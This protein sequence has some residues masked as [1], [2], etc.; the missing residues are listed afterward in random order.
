MV[1]HNGII[2]QRLRADLNRNGQWKQL[3]RI[4]QVFNQLHSISPV[5]ASKRNDQ[6]L[7]LVKVHRHSNMGLYATR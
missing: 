2:Q 7:L 1:F 4:I 5:V 3:P 6:P